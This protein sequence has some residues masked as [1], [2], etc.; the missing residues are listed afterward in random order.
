MG[1]AQLF[2]YFNILKAPEGER[3]DTTG[4]L[5]GTVVTKKKKDQ[6][7]LHLYLCTDIVTAGWKVKWVVN[8]VTTDAVGSS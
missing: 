7:Y 3:G 5:V 8:L 1:F 4:T 2:N 6:K